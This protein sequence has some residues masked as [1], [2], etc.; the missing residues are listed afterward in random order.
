MRDLAN[1]TTNE[2]AIIVIA[3][4]YSRPDAKDVST[5]DSGGLKRF[6]LVAI[7]SRIML[8]E[9]LWTEWALFNGAL[10]TI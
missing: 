6:L 3:A 7:G 4:S 8:Q 9:N 10:R 2:G 1:P 5:E